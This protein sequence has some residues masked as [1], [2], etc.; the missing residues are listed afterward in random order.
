MERAY[1]VLKNTF[2]FSSFRLAQ[3]EVIERLLVENENALVLFPTGG[4]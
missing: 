3:K 4:L 2:G 1:D